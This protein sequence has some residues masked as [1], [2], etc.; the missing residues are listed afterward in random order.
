M[1]LN[2]CAMSA[3]A[4]FKGCVVSCYVMSFCFSLRA[5]IGR[6]RINLEAAT[7][8][9]EPEPEPEA[10][11]ADE[12]EFVEAEEEE[13]EEE[14]ETEAAPA[15]ATPLLNPLGFRAER[16]D[17]SVSSTCRFYCVWA[18]PNLPL[19]SGIHWGEG[20]LAYRKL[21]EINGSLGGL[22]FQRCADFDSAKDLFIERAAEKGADP[23]DAQR[24]FH[25]I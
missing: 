22:K 25:W 8:S 1:K 23:R 24:G 14:E 20:A 10:A 6:L 4:S 3:A 2:V 5:T 21:I 7:S 13:E 17:S 19:L 9:P 12:F 11:E 18:I 16:P 15:E